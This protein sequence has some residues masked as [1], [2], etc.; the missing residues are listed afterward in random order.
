MKQKLFLKFILV[1]LIFGILAFITVS[2]FLSSMALTYLTKIK[3]NDLYKEANMV[4][5]Q[6]AIN[7]YTN[8]MSINDVKTH[9]KVLDNYLSAQIWIMDADGTVILNTRDS[10]SGE[11]IVVP[12]F[13]PAANTDV[14]YQTGDF[15]NVFSEKMLSVFYPITSGIT[16][17]GY[18][19]IHVP[20]SNIEADR[21][22]VLNL[23]YLA[24]LIVFALSLLIL[25]AFAKFVYQPLRKISK[26]TGEYA[27]GNFDHQI[28]LHSD[29]EMGQL[30]DSL[31]Y[32]ASELKQ[33]RDYQNRFIANVSH[34]FRSPLTSIKGYLAAMQDGTIP[35]EMQPRYFDIVLSETDRLSKLTESLLTLNSLNPTGIV[36]NKTDFDINQV[37]KA[38]AASFEGTCRGKQI[39]L[40]LILTGQTLYVCADVTKIQQV[41]YNLLDN[42]IKFSHNN[43]QI[44]IETT[45]KGEKI[46]ISVK[47]YG[48]G[49]PKESLNQI[50]ERFYKTD[51]SR[52]KDKRGTGLGLSIVKEIIQNHNENI[53]VISTVDV[54][55]EFIFTLTKSK[56]MEDD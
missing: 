45:E 18:V 56:N 40:E 51:L 9:L 17:K 52:G 13:D 44:R 55:T 14:H 4:S 23:C 49:I 41:L 54:G 30:A 27:K 47:D 3:A 26:G 2:T 28:V 38:T 48:I 11:V 21:D 34:D 39:S 1:Y 50:F 16:I 22:Y 15:Y 19:I 6:Y 32:M 43:S 46:F 35:V 33:S 37:I 42:A 5:T 36:L 31:N 25:G 10:G 20:T 8:Q 53:N 7:Y 24:L 12:D 29:D